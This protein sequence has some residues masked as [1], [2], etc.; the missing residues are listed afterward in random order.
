MTVW[1]H[2]TPA[3]GRQLKLTV[4]DPGTPDSKKISYGPAS[5][6]TVTSEYEVIATPWSEGS[7]PGGATAFTERSQDETPWTERDGAA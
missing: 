4:V 3:P 2:N 7:Q 1:G 6:L 5:G